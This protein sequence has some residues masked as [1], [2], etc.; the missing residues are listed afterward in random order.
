MTNIISSTN[1]VDWTVGIFTNSDI[2]TTFINFEFKNSKLFV[3]EKP[4][5]EWKLITSEKTNPE[6]MW[7]CPKCSKKVIIHPNYTKA[8]LEPCIGSGRCNQTENIIKQMI[9]FRRYKFLKLEK[10]E[11]ISTIIVHFICDKGHESNLKYDSLR[12]GSSCKICG[13]E[14]RTG[15]KTNGIIESTT[16]TCSCKKKVCEHHNHELRCPDSAKEWA[17]DLNNGKSPKDF[18]PA[19]KKSAWWR[20]SNEWCKMT[21]EQVIGG[22]SG[23][24]HRCPYCAGHKVCH[25]NCLA[26]THPE[27]IKEWDYENNKEENPETVTHGSNKIVWWIC[28][29]HEPFF[30]YQKS[31]VERISQLRNCPKCNDPK[32]EQRVGG[33]EF[34]VQEARKIHGDKYDYIEEYKGAMIKIQIYC[35]VINDK[36]EVHGIFIQTPAMHKL[37]QSCP[38]CDIRYDQMMGGHEQF[39]KD[40]RN[41]HGDKY[42]YIEEYK[43]NEVKIQIYCPVIN[44]KG[45]VHGIFMKTP[46]KHKSGQ[47][48]NK[49]NDP[50][51]NQL[52]GGHDYFVQEARKVHGDKYDYIEEYKGSLIKIKIY[53]PKLNKHNLPHGIFYQN[54]HRHK[55]GDGCPICA[56]ENNKSKLCLLLEDLISNNGYVKGVNWI[57]E[58]KHELLRYINP[59]RIDNLLTD[60]K[61]AIEIDGI[62]HFSQSSY[63]TPT[64]TLAI[65]IARDIYKD[66]FCLENGFSLMRIPCNHKNS[67][68]YFKEVLNLCKQ[69]YIIYFTYKHYFDEIIKLVNLDWS[70]VY[71][72]IIPCPKLKF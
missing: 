16:K 52:V 23:K 8:G 65:R 44:E 18:S 60:V 51:Y 7:K 22:R 59:L 37:G 26:T 24:G 47:G 56:N 69:G 72:L 25:W 2:K 62:Q 67:V 45:E 6:A 58:Y 64:N 70:K 30:H 3:M 31:V 43:G 33:H 5:L 14:N 53:C 35:P 46:H 1:L 9:D 57:E 40:A 29:N 27:I 42:D 71:V 21:Y 49:C 32:Y 54:P 10:A 55:S 13:N 15:K 38:K 66:K 12:K 20:C 68:N 17:Y 4:E 50:R 19:S 28:K 36:G 48:C 34:F 41:I 11:K 61:L 39:V 63:D